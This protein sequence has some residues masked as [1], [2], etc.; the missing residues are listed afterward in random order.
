[1]LSMNEYEAKKKASRLATVFT[2]F[3]LVVGTAVLPKV[4]CSQVADH[5]PSRGLH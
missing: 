2:S 4:A 3:D 5:D 1:M